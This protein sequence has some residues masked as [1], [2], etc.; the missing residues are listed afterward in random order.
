MGRVGTTQPKWIM[1]LRF[2]MFSFECVLENKEEIEHFLFLL[3]NS[4]WSRSSPIAVT[5]THPYFFNQRW[6]RGKKKVM[7]LRNLPLPEAC[8]F[9]GQ[10]LDMTE[11]TQPGLDVLYIFTGSTSPVGLSAAR[12]TASFFRTQHTELKEK[13]PCG[14]LHAKLTCSPSHSYKQGRQFYSLK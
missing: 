3:Y 5:C 10:P 8:L 6:E 7:M 9:D 1:W 14:K 2:E 11:I 13:S 4:S 12:L